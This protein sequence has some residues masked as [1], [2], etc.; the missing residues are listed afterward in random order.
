[1]PSPRRFT[2]WPGETRRRP[3]IPR[4][5]V[6]AVVC[7]SLTGSSPA[8]ATNGTWSSTAATSA[9]Q[10]PANWIGGN[11]PGLNSGTVNP[12]TAIFG[13]TSSTI[14]ITP[15][16]NRNLEFITF[17]SSASSY[18]IGTTGGN[19]LLLTAGGTIQN[20]SALVLG[21]V[22]TINAPLTLEGSYTFANNSTMPTL[23]VFGGPITDAA[24]GFQ[25]L[26]ISGLNNMTINSAI[27]G[28]TG[29]IALTKSGNGTLTLNGNNTFTGGVTI[30]S[31]NISLA[32][33]GALNSTTPNFVNLTSGTASLTLGGNS[34]AVSELSGSGV[35]QNSNAS[36]AT[37][38]VN[39]IPGLDTFSG[40][41]Q[42]GGGGGKLALTKNGSGT[43]VLS[44]NNA[45][46]GGVT[47]N[48]GLVQMGS[49]GALN[50]W[51]PL[52][53]TCRHA[54]LSIL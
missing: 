5:I 33:A 47:I 23:L 16:A 38:T 43:L 15:D 31:G 41:L 13:T 28:G 3:F 2:R 36:N 42:D 52:E 6:T 53:S 25:T 22:E 54:S 14:L 27:G 10:T 46:S 34:V 26:A 40:T 9:W 11:L 29:T 32:N 7:L 20:T 35:V 44:G 24:S 50:S 17:D 51:D 45:F 48:S 19:A 8:F 39:P 1:M 21:A 4:W 49:S 30:N 18:T 37:L 12:D